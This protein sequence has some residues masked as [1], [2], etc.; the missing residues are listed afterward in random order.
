MAQ[1]DAE[2]PQAGYRARGGRPRWGTLVLVVVLHLAAFAGLLRAFAPDFTSA[3]VDAAVSIVS[4]TVT[5]PPEPEPEAVPSPDPEPQPDEG[6]AAEEAAEA[7]PREE[8]VPPAPM[9]RPSPSPAPRAASTGVADSA[10]AGDTGSGTGAGGDGEGLGSGRSGGGRGGVPVTRPVKIAGDINSAADFP[11]PAGGRQ[12]R[13]GRQVVVYMTVGVDGRASNCRVV[14]PGPDPE[15][16]RITC[17]LAEERFRFRP[18]S[19]ADGNPV[20]S[21]YGWRQ[22]W[23]APR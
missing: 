10:G 1:G 17:Q 8:V 21:T 9:P 5:A 20:P 19:D 12:I 4:V 11:T 3:A 2:Q 15:A 23:E 14:E 18:A 22:W 7:T 6:A 13:W 16:G